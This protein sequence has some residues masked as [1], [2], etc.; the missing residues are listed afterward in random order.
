MKSTIQRAPRIANTAIKPAGTVKTKE[1][2]WIPN[3]KAVTKASEV[4]D[5]AI[6]LALY[7]ALVANP[8]KTKKAN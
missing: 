8:T 3:R 5:S 6:G 1:T 7:N 2:T 4:S